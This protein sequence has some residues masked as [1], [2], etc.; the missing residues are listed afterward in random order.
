MNGAIAHFGS[1][2]ADETTI[3]FR[4]ATS[5]YPNWG[6]SEQRRSFKLAG[7]TLTTRS[8]MRQSAA[9]PRRWCEAR[10]VAHPPLSAF[11][12]AALTF[13]KSSRPA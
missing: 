3:T 10:E 12:T 8:A 7:D 1:Y 13:E 4:I 6:G 9:A 2:S 11:F 5:T